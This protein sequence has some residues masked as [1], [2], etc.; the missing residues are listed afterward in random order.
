MRALARD[1]FA[2][3]EADAVVPH[4]DFG[5]IIAYE[6]DGFGGA[7]LMDD[8]NVP[9]LLS[10]PLFFNLTA[11]AGAGGKSGSSSPFVVQSRRGLSSNSTKKDRRAAKGETPP[12]RDYGQI[13]RNTRKFVLSDAN[14]YYAKGPVISAVGGPHLGPGRAWPMAALV[15]GLTAYEPLS[16]NR[17]EKEVQDEVAEQLRMV[18]DS[19]DGAGVVHESVNSWDEKAWTRSWFGWANGLFGELILRIEE[20]EKGKDRGLLSRSWQ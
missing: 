8:A 17:S 9:S 6:V 15:A 11:G 18:L 2:G 13:Y 10:I 3:F 20:Q 5:D 7:N 16:G 12:A 19:T 14:P 4:R 1:I